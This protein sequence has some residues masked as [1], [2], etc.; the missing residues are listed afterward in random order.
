V[1]AIDGT[2]A[3]FDPSG[4]IDTEPEAIAPDSTIAGN[5]LDQNSTHSGF[6]RSADGTLT[7]LSAPKATASTVHDINRKDVVLGQEVTFIRK[8]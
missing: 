4:S 2:I 3:T 5:Y 7:T 1:R 8:R 6:V